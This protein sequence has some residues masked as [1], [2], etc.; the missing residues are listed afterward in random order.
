MKLRATEARKKRMVLGE[1]SAKNDAVDIVAPEP[2]EEAEIVVPRE[3][4]SENKENQ[5]PKLRRVQIAFRNRKEND[6]S[7]RL[8]GWLKKLMI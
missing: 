4:K 1:V 5:E 8:I 3:E 6:E 2:R 7:A